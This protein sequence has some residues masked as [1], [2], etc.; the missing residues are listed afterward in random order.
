MSLT[1][2][3]DKNLHIFRD[4]FVVKKRVFDERSARSKA[5]LDDSSIALDTTSHQRVSK[6]H[7]SH[8]LRGALSTL[9]L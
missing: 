2:R 6:L 5:V 3:R 4:E 1:F 7:E 8:N 9:F